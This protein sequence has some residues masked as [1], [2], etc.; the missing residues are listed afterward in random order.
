MQNRIQYKLTLA[1]RMHPQRS[2]PFLF[3]YR[4][5]VV[6]CGR[7]VEVLRDGAS[8]VVFEIPHHILRLVPTK[9]CAFPP[10]RLLL[11][12]HD[13]Y[14]LFHH[15][16]R[17]LPRQ[18]DVLIPRPSSFSS[19]LLLC[20]YPITHI[21]YNVVRFDESIEWDDNGRHTTRFV[22]HARYQSHEPSTIEIAGFPD[23]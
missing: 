11:L 21:I 23:C 15:A 16:P 14:P 19:R 17:A 6:D 9:T 18:L 4:T 5:L 3:R 7:V 20:D 13:H 12:S 2:M 8:T 10:A 22:Y 1:E